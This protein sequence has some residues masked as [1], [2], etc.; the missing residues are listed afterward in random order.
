M[1]TDVYV[2]ECQN[3]EHWPVVPNEEHD[4]SIRPGFSSDTP[5]TQ[6]PSQIKSCF[7]QNDP[8]LIS[9]VT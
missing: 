4:C 1:N 3:L 8:R 9:F 5:P 2:E 7:E 6:R